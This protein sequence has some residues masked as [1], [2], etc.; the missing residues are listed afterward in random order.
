VSV[1]VYNT[2]SEVHRAVDVLAEVRRLFL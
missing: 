1:G 2:A